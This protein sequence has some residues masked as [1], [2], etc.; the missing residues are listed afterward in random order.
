MRPPAHS[1]GFWTHLL[2]RFR[3]PI[4][5]MAAAIGGGTAGYHLIEGWGFLD[6]LYMTVTTLTT[7]GF[8]EVNPLSTAGR[9]FTM[10]LVLFGVFTLFTSIGIVGNIALTGELGEPLRRRRMQRRID[11]LRD[12]FVICAYGRVGRAAAEEFRLQG[13]R[14]VIVEQQE[15]LERIIGLDGAPYIIDD[16]TAEAV[17]VR[18]GIECARGLVCAVDSDAVNVYITLTARSL[19]PKLSIVARASN[20]ESVDQLHRAGADRVISPYSLSGRRMASLAS[21]PSVVDFFDMV[22]VAPDLRLE[23][24]VV[25]SGSPMDGQTVG[26]VCATR[27][28]MTILAVKK[29]GDDLIPSPGDDLRLGAGDL[30]VAMGPVKTLADLAAPA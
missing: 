18:A 23:E 7:V 8:R 9:M 28:Q 15:A 27:D 16:P 25:R 12:H 20:P 13:E 24:I 5:L 10:G 21:Q 17:L 29:T 6:A 2:F 1:R 19:N 30:V 14:Y 4:L 26:E 22:T 3:I 11:A